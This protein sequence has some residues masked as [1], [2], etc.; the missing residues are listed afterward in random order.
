[1]NKVYFLPLALAA[2]F[3]AVADETYTNIVTGVRF[4][5]DEVV[6]TAIGGTWTT[7]G[8]DLVRT[9]SDAVE[10]D[11]GDSEMQLNITAAPADT[12]TIVRIEVEATLADAVELSDV[13]TAQTGFAVCTNSYNAWN[14]DEW[15]A[16]DEVPSGVDDTK[17]TNL[18]VEVSYQ[19]PG[20]RKARFTVGNTVL[21]QRSNSAEWIELAT[22]SNSI[23]GL[24]FFGAGTLAKAD[25]SVMLGVAEYDGV[26]YGTLSDAVA[27][28]ASDPS[29][30]INVVRD[31]KGEI[32]VPEGAT[33]VVRPDE[34]EFTPSTEGVVI[35]TSGAYTIPVNI[36]GGTVELKL[37]NSMSNKEIVGTPDHTGSTI[38][39]TI[40]TATSVLEGAKPDGTK[41]LAVNAN[42]RN[43]LNTHAQDAYVAAD[44][45][46]KSIENALK[47]VRD[48]ENENGLP[49]YQSYALGIAPTDSV[50][51]VTVA[52]DDAPDGVSLS[53]PALNG[54]TP[55]G[56]YEIT[57]KVGD[58]PVTAD[59]VKIPLPDPGTGSSTEVKISFK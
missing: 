47:E 55:S 7:T 14:G 20:V 28:A 54:K 33:V 42:L 23:A 2:A 53:I 15:V 26:K 43:Y 32:T 40:Q 44:V 18:M 21:R 3:S 30:V 46:S 8:C 50:K 19:Y 52:N 12:N 34:S 59:A 29:P 13:N 27:A 22:T 25:A 24:G 49:L 51:P 31:V 16:L 39:F 10:F 41:A 58:T 57:Y 48:G 36:S 35:G 5:G 17:V 4:V 6:P 56:D 38:S 45:T 9:A 11:T 1:M 37:P